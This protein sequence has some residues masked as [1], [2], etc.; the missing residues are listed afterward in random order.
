MTNQ[1][2]G[3]TTHTNGFA[4]KHTYL[5]MIQNAILTLNERGGST[6]KE[7]WHCIE[8]RFPHEA[9]ERNFVLALKKLVNNESAV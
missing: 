7:I 2:N 6:R 4:K 9:T 8:T 1:A 5:E 3:N